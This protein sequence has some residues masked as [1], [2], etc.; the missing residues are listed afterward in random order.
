MSKRSEGY[1]QRVIRGPLTVLRA[2]LANVQFA[3]VQIAAIAVAASVGVALKQLP[4]YALLSASDYATEMGKLRVIYEPTLGPLTGLFE[5]LG[6]F[7]IFTAPWF[8]ALLVLLT[9]SIVVCTFD[10]LPKIRAVTARSRAE[11]PSAFFDPTLAG[12]G[13]MTLATTIS[14][15]EIDNAAK[16]VAREMRASG[17][18]ARFVTDPE[19]TGGRIIHGDRFRRSYRFTL[20]MHTGLVLMLVGAALSGILGYT[21]GI[22]LTNGEALPVG[23]IG[24]VGG[25]VIENRGFSAPRTATG[26]FAD[27]ATDLAV[28]QDGVQVAQQ[29]VRVNAPLSYNGWSFHQNFFGPTAVLEIQSVSG[30]LLWSG[31]APFTSTAEGAPYATLPIPGSDAGVEL[32]LQ[33]D[34]SGAAAVL[35]VASEPVSAGSSELRTLFASVLAPGETASAPG[36]TFSVHLMKLSSYTGIIARRDP[37]AVIVWLAAALIMVGL[38]LTLRRPRARLWIRIRPSQ[39]HADATLL[40][41]RGARAEQAGPLLRRIATTLSATSSDARTVST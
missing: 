19:D 31:E 34:A 13:G 32:L 36:G 40:L 39:A 28:Y 33:R 18:D 1:H 12:R 14:A 20:V 30:D 22:L 38:T 25:L 16:R 3:M 11:Q 26:A 21:Q 5:R 10:R 29:I 41:E 2:L 8:S 7:R 23:K 17:W 15:Q 4:D 27:F 6:F 35:V 37:A 24:S 9:I